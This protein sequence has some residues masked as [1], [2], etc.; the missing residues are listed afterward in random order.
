MTIHGL[1]VG[2]AALEVGYESA[3][4]FTREYKRLF[5][6]TPMRDMRALRSAEA[7]RQEPLRGR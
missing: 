7:A 6:L 3:S 2:S 4:Q 5:G 1:D